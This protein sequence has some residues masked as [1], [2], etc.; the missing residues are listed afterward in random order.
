MYP[1]GDVNAA[2]LDAVDAGVKV[3][4]GGDPYPALE[5]HSLNRLLTLTCNSVPEALR[6]FQKLFLAGA[7]R[8]GID[9]AALSLPRGNG[10]SWLAG[11]LVARVLTPSHEL[12]RPGTESVLCAASIE[13]ARIVFR[14]ARETLEPTGA[15]R[16]LDSNT[17]IGI[18]HKASNTRLRVIGSNG[19]TA[20]GLVQCPWAICDEPGAWETNGGQLVHDAIETAKGKPGSPLKAVYIGTLA[21][22]RGGWWHDLVARGSHGSTYVQALQGA[23]ERWD[24]WSEIR[25][26]NP[27]VEISADFR[28]KLLEERDEARADTRL[29]A[30]FLSYRLNIPTGDESTT[31]LTVENWQQICARPVAT[32]DGGGAIVGIDLGAGRSWSSAVAIWPAGRV[33]AIATAPGIPDLDAQERRD[34]VP[35]GTYRA[36]RELGALRVADGLHVQPPAQL[37]EA[38]V[39]AWGSPELLIADRARFFELRDA[40]G[41]A[42]PLVPRVTRWFAAADDVRALRKLALDGPLSCAENSRE[43]LGASLSAA[44]VKSDDQGSTRLV[45]RGTNSEGRDDVAAALLLAAGEF[46]RRRDVPPAA[47]EFEHLE[48][49]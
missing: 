20:L 8:P 31:L 7:T 24:S 21:P 9:T 14:F 30:R 2:E 27:L 26:C 1:I 48:T 10:K 3:G 17:R 32:R 36:L 22:A 15:Y 43:L 29:K 13:Q 46:K 42:A 5:R 28:A 44:A 45:K 47:F 4:H 19:K 12:F 49:A 16:F 38:I 18:L 35:A 6:N 25:R 41:E 11:E 37:W 39:E 33:E 23:P 40:I 34:R